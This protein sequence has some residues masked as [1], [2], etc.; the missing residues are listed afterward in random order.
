MPPKADDEIFLLCLTNHRKIA[1]AH[2]RAGVEV[3]D[4]ALDHNARNLKVYICIIDDSTDLHITYYLVLST[5][6]PR[7]CNNLTT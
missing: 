5:E 7:D 3:A 6:G 4:I 2:E 1:E